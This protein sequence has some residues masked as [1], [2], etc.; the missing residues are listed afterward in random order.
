MSFR[1]SDKLQRYEMVEFNPTDVIRLPG[2]NSSQI[3]TGYKFTITDRS[4][5]FDYYNGYFMV[6]KE[7]Q[8]K[9]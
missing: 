4:D 7:L 9:S 5:F 1:T 8:K 6:T 2:N 3:K